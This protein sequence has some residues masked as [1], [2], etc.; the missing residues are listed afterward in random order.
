MSALEYGG[1]VLTSLL[2]QA[3][4]QE[5]ICLIEAFVSLTGDTLFALGCGR[6]FEGDPKTMW[7]SLSKLIVLPDETKVYCA[8]E[9]PGEV[10]GI[11]GWV[12]GHLELTSQRDLIL[13][14]KLYVPCPVLR[15]TH[16]PTPALR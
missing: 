1:A 5:N 3:V 4:R 14:S 6:L 12:E 7:A 13:S 15:S 2:A 11:V 10:P 16:S 9:V 8:H